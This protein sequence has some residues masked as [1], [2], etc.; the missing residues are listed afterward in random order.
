MVRLRVRELAAERRLPAFALSAEQGR[1]N[2]GSPLTYTLTNNTWTAYDKKGYRY[3]FGSDDTSRQYDTA[4]T[5]TNTFKWYLQEIRDPNNNYVKYTYARDNN[6]LYPTK[7]TY[8]GS[9]ATDGPM[10]I[11]AY[12]SGDGRLVRIAQS[13]SF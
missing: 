13:R 11:A 6:E 4:T 3:L 7:I 8:T 5:S 12:P 2:D 9:G 1:V 10:P